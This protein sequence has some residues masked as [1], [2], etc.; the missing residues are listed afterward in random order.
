[1]VAILT[2]FLIIVLFFSKTFFFQELYYIRDIYGVGYQ[3]MHLVIETLKAG[4][5][6]LWNPYQ[7][8]GVPHL[9]NPGTMSLYPL[10]LLLCLTGLTGSTYIYFLI[11]HIFLAGV[12]FYALMRHWNCSPVPAWLAASSYMLSGYAVDF[13]FNP[14]FAWI[15]LIFLFL[16]RALNPKPRTEKKLWPPF[17]SLPSILLTGGFLGLQF[18]TGGIEVVFFTLL[19]LG[20]YVGFMSLW[21]SKSRLKVFTRNTGIFMLILGIGISLAMVQFLPSR[22][23]ALQSAR[24]K[25]LDYEAASSHA[26]HPAGLIEFFIPHF[27]GKKTDISFWGEPFYDNHYAYFI[28]IY[29]GVSTLLLGMLTLTCLRHR[30]VS[31]LLILLILSILL[32]LGPYTPIHYLVYRYVPFMGGLR[33]PV[34]YLVLTTFAASALGGFGAQ[35]L[36]IKKEESSRFL[37]PLKR[38]GFFFLCLGGLLLAFLLVDFLSRGALFQRIFG[39]YISLEKLQEATPYVHKEIFTSSVF[40]LAGTGV[41]IL[42]VT[43]KLNP[44]VSGILL[45]F[46]VTIDLFSAHLHL[47]PT[48][49]EPFY[50]EPPAVINLFDKDARLHRFYRYAYDIPEIPDFVREDPLKRYSWFKNTLFPYYSVQNHLYDVAGTFS[51]RPMDYGLLLHALEIAPWSAKLKLLSLLNVR[52]L[53][54]FSPLKDERLRPIAFFPDLKM[55]VYENT[56]YLPRAYIV[57]RS[58]T[59]KKG[60]E[61]LNTFI[62]DDFDPQEEVVLL[63]E[64]REAGSQKQEAKRESRISSSLLPSSDYERRDPYAPPESSWKE[65]FASQAHVIDYSPTR[66]TIETETSQGGYLVFADSYYPGW[67]A[68]VDGQKREIL[69]VNYILRAVTL[70]PGVHTIQFKYE[71]FSYKMGLFLSLMAFMVWMGSWMILTL[72]PIRSVKGKKPNLHRIHDT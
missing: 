13:E 44:R 34:K 30:L 46:I 19:A 4:Y 72:Y 23:L 6:P 57:P 24:V 21:G 66:A 62:R 59:V 31:Y 15:P 38:I 61:A 26:L 52:Y 33:I 5:I 47:H 7:L 12:F 51:L 53:L 18:L 71:P 37:S 10:N 63:E 8:S 35:I 27:F 55:G 17:S 36:L 65:P 56:A 40:L 22:E 45:S 41:V 20:L 3:W 64:G 67:R 68:S 16:D 54:G 39:G 2:L 25:G 32:M 11:L 49:T 50:S 69:R 70:E 9:A 1:M 58:R 60:V 48:V 42:T 43:S 14:P 28:S 29:F